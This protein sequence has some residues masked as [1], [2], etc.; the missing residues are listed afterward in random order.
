MKWALLA[1]LAVTTAASGAQR[2]LGLSG[3]TV[4]A[5]GSGHHRCLIR[6]NDAASLEKVA[7]ARVEL[8]LPLS[9][10][11]APRTLRLAAFPVTRAWSP[12]AVSW[13]NGWTSP[14]GDFDEEIMARSEVDLRGGAGEVRMDVTEHVRQWVAGEKPC[15]GLLL[16][17][18]PEF[19]IGVATEDVARLQAPGSAKLRVVY[20]KV[21]RAPRQDG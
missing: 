11:A 17:V 21:G 9:G 13:T 18:P 19:G 20:R 12:E 8:V 3:L 16:S 10:L 4:I 1:L 5:D 7:I 2:E 15:N 14:G 6:V